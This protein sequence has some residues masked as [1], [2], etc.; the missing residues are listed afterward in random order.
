MRT[1]LLSTF[2]VVLLV[3]LVMTHR[4][5][6]VP[7]LVH[8]DLPNQ[9]ESDQ[10]KQ[11]TLFAAC[12]SIADLIRDGALSDPSEVVAAFHIETANLRTNKQWS[13][14]QERIETLLREACDVDEQEKLLREIDGRQQTADGSRK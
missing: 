9:T 2:F 5:T 13:A 3:L 6:Y 11:A 10:R 14:I 12:A 4:G 1:S 8:V 7:P